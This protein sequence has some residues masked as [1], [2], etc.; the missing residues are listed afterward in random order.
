M[1]RMAA[2]SVCFFVGTLA[3]QQA[4]RLMIQSRVAELERERAEKAAR[5]TPER[6]IR[7]ERIVN[8]VLAN[9]FVKAI[10]G[11]TNG[12][13]LKLGGLITGSG[14]AAGPEYTRHDLANDTMTFRAWVS[15]SVRGFWQ[16]RT[17]LDMPKL[18]GG[19]LFAGLS[20]MHRDYPEIEYFGAG[21]RSSK[22]TETLWGLRDS[23]VS[24]TAGVRPF[25]HFEIG[26]IGRFLSEDASL[27]PESSSGGSVFFRAPFSPLNST[28]FAQTASFLQIDY[29]DR[30]GEPHSGGLY[31]AGVANYS[32]LSSGAHSFYRAAAELQQY[33]SFLNGTHVIALHGRAEFSDPRRGNLVPFYLQP[34]LGGPDTLR[35]FE[36][37]RFRDNNAVVFNAEYRW[38]LYQGLDAALFADGGQVFTDWR[39]IELRHLETSFGFG[40]RFLQR[41]RVFL[42]LDTGFSRE[43]FQIW[44]KFGNMFPAAFRNFENFY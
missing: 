40:L 22:D 9:P 18:A 33:I 39:R 24:A 6:P 17:E 38:Q 11:E 7:G 10:A 21:P 20:A 42:R 1:L 44:F 12:L 35:G 30:E 14:F 43:G 8:R 27:S 2:L 32:D 34:V 28:S 16:A 37:F 19:R 13:G 25:A 15:G 4:D 5:L 41:E 29:L 3:A 26:A 23:W 36:P 31:W